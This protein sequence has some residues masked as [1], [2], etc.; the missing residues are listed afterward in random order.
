MFGPA[1][2]AL[3]LTLLGGVIAGS[4]A[5]AQTKEQCAQAYEDAQS[6]Q[7]EHRL[8]E[9][10]EQLVTCTHEKCP[11]AVSADCWRWLASVEASTPTLVIAARSAAGDDLVDVTLS[12]DGRA[13]E[14]EMIG[15]AMSVDPGPHVLRAEAPGFLPAEERVVVREGEKARIF[16]L[17][18]APLPRELSAA[19][20]PA[21]EAAPPEPEPASDAG[22]ARL[23]VA[24]YVLFG[25][26]VAAAGA[27]TYLAYDGYRDGKTMRDTCRPR[28]DDSEVDAARLRLTLG[29]AAL[30]L[31]AAALAS[32]LVTILVASARDAEETPEPS[33]EDSVGLDVALLPRGGFAGL[34]GRF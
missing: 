9:A 18:L 27:G 17:V 12:L 15:K 32:G 26:G 23:K 21:V 3:V 1:R 34:R 6:L 10:R 7:M 31:G 5:H 19:E 8:L 22:R 24:S 30:G 16:S 14:N 29:H 25:V 33:D 4:S 11:K 13:V 2:L 20:A 28:C